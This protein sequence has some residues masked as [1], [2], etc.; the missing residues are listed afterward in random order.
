MAEPGYYL[1]NQFTGKVYPEPKPAYAD[2]PP[3]W[4]KQIT[5]GMSEDG[6]IRRYSQFKA[7][8]KPPSQNFPTSNTFISIVNGRGSVFIRLNSLDELKLLLSQMASWIPEMEKVINDLKP[9]E[10]QYQMAYK[11]FAEA[12]QGGNNHDR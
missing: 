10:I 6:D 9:L 1:P 11:A 3:V 8:I 2:T 7:W 4:K 5:L 12:M